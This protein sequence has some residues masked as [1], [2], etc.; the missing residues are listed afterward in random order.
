MK[1]PAIEWVVTLEVYFKGNLETK[2]RFHITC[3]SDEVNALAKVHS[4]EL[5]RKH[6]YPATICVVITPYL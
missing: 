1:K 5:R 6:P 2:K 4:E 3:T